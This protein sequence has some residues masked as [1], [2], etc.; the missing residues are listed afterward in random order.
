MKHAVFAVAL[1]GLLSLGIAAADTSL[2]S[3]HPGPNV[4][5]TVAQCKMLKKP[6]KRK[7][8]KVCVKR[9][10]KHHFHPLKKVGQ[11]CRPNNG[12]P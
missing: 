3:A 7:A 8:C 6:A 5:R 1:A 4:R 2:A 9:P 10:K 11:R 12:K